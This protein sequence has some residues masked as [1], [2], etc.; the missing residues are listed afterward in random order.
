MQHISQ[1]FREYRK[2]KKI[3]S[4][5]TDIRKGIPQHLMTKPVMELSMDDYFELALCQKEVSCL[6]GQIL[7]ILHELQQEGEE[8]EVA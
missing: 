7:E 6:A 5:A 8:K 4:L 2:L 1:V 3:E